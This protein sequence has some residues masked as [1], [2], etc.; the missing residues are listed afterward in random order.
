MSDQPTTAQTP[1]QAQQPQF[2][3]PNLFTL[4]GGGLHVSYATSGFDGK[5]HFTY[6]DPLRTLSFSGG[7]IRTADVQ[8]LGLVVVSVTIV[9]S[10]DAGTTTFSLLVPRVNLTGQFATTPVKTIGVTT[11]HAFSI[12]Q[13]FNQGQR[14]FYSVT[15]LDGTASNVVF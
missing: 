10:I 2:V 6:Q 11:Q 1:Q 5:P 3:Q 14:D 7:E 13:A 12:V 15:A 8:D 4:A 9:P